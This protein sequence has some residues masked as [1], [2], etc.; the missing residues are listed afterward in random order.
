MKT[1]SHGNKNNVMDNITIPLKSVIE[2]GLSIN[3]Y[4][5]LYDISTGFTISNLLD[6]SI[7]SL[8]SLE[9]KGF[10]KMS[11]MLLYWCNTKF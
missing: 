4:L 1:I 11:D 2:Q 10:I 6:N 8:I 7:G 5:L 9:E 3:E